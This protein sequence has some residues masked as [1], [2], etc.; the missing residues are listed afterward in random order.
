[1]LS[2]ICLE[3]TTFARH[4]QRLSDDLQILAENL[5]VSLSVLQFD[6]FGMSAFKQLPLAPLKLRPDGAL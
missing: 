3:L 6:T 5:L 2:S 1:M 4:Q